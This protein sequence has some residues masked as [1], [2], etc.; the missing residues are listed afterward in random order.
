MLVDKWVEGA[1]NFV[2]EYAESTGVEVL[3]GIAPETRGRF[4]NPNKCSQVRIN[5]IIDEPLLGPDGKPLLTKSY[6]ALVADEKRWLP[7]SKMKSVF[8][9]EGNPTIVMAKQLYS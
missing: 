8:L 6:E 9:N 2:P 1:W 5:Q 4:I 7:V 3:V